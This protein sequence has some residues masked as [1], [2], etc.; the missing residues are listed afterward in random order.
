MNNKIDSIVV[1]GQMVRD[2]FHTAVGAIRIYRRDDRAGKQAR[3]GGHT[4][5][6]YWVTTLPA[7]TTVNAG[8]SCSS[9]SWCLTKTVRMNVRWS[10]RA[11]KRIWVTLL[12]AGVGW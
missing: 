12:R 11:W 6:G 10:A 2:E 4:N 8:V 3:W 1:S 9:I 5:W 7:S